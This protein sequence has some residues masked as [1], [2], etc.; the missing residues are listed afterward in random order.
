MGMRNKRDSKAVGIQF[1]SNIEPTCKC[2]KALAYQSMQA[3]RVRLYRGGES[4]RI[5]SGFGAIVG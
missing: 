3:G 2:Y 5:L 1:S 4:A